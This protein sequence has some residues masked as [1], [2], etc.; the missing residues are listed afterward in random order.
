VRLR[1]NGTM[2]NEEYYI[3]VHATFVGDSFFSN[4]TRNVIQFLEI[5]VATTEFTEKYFVVGES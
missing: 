3:F 1:K 4:E 2:M 5:E